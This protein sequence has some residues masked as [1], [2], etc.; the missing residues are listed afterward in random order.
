VAGRL[1]L[2]VAAPPMRAVAAH[3]ER[4]QGPEAL[5]HLPPQQQ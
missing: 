2:G 1:G 3:D 4:G 5:L